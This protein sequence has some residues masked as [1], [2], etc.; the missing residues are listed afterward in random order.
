MHDKTSQSEQ[1]P[2]SSVAGEAATFF[3]ATDGNDSWSGTVAA[4]DSAGTDGPF[5]TLVRARNAVR[6]LKTEQGEQ[7]K[8]ITVMVRGG[9][10]YLETTFD[11]T[12]ADSGT[13][14]APITYCAHPGETPVI[15]GGRPITGWEPHEGKILKCDLPETRGGAWSFRQLF[16]NGERLDRSRYPNP[17]PED[18]LWNGKW[19]NSEPD[20]AALEASN[21]YIVWKEPGAFPREWS[22]PSQGE[23]F[24]L[25][26][27]P[28]WGDSCMIR[29]T[30]IDRENGTI[31]LAHSTRDFDANPI[32]WPKE[33]HRPDACRFVVENMLEELNR[34]GEWCLD[35]E[36]GV[37]YFWPPD[38]DIEDSEV[39]APVLKRLV[40][41]RCV[42]HVR[43][44]GFVF[45]ETR[46]GEPSSHYTDVEGVG[47]M[48]PQMDWEYCG[49]AVYLNACRNCHVEN[50]RITVVGGNGVYLRNHNEN[51]VIRGNEISYA[52]ANGVVLAGARRAMQY[53][54]GMDRPENPHPVFNEVSDNDIHHC[55]LYDTYAAGVFLGMGNWNRIIH[56]DIH[57]L[58]HH[59]I[60]LGA[61]RYGRQYLEYNRISRTC[62][63][64]SDH[65]AIN[66][67]HEA[68]AEEDPP[69]HVIR[70]NYISDTGNPDSGIVMG[71]YLDNWSSQCLVQGNI[72]VNTA[73]GMRS[74]SIL[75][76]GRNNIIENN[77]LVDTGMAH[78]CMMAHC[79]YPEF[80]TV[81]ARNIMCDTTGKLPAF[82]DLADAARPWRVVAESSDNLFLKVGDDDPVI[83][84]MVP[85]STEHG[86]M[87]GGGEKAE[88]LRMT[89]WRK[90]HGR[91]EDVYDIRSVVADPLFVDAANGDFRLK[92]ES[93]ALALG[94]QP[95]PIER[96]GVREERQGTR[97]A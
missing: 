51:N 11:L 61:S 91:G 13:A 87:Y 85:L 35:G 77:I 78:I 38:G 40:F 56:N 58:P 92:P 7:R 95:I 32:F 5:A 12:A 47:A 96:I 66:C 52:G 81:I 42:S 8:P 76:K 59:G 10:Y 44:S 14:E 70:Y 4:P 20:A 54:A 65:G 26:T 28:L 82:I 64:T 80:A 97:D 9:R 23:L 71:I 84:K 31:G 21:P 74:Y 73:P 6:A 67:W 94:F 17:D 18:D 19:A 53:G 3:V 16:M 88:W 50:N 49:E 29:I 27:A 57:D 34:P 46:G 63:V 41:M 30:S 60:N 1:H 25:P 45:T 36:D 22:K 93:P 2:S 72:V 62:L 37:L 83:V 89:E 86:E 90:A 48:R 15:S 33:Y 43:V 79:F 55:G 24:L 69:G 68:P 39:V 75:V